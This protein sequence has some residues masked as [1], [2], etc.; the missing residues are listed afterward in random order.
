M[1]RKRP[2]SV[3]PKC[4]TY[5]WVVVRITRPSLG[6]Y[7]S[8]LDAARTRKSAEARALKEVSEGGG[9]VA[10]LQYRDIFAPQVVGKAPVSSRGLVAPVAAAATAALLK[11]EYENEED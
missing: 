4:N 1:P 8:T 11:D 2:F 5:P 6:I 9:V 3:V 10:V 7:F